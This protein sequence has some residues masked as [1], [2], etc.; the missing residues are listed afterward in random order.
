MMVG[1][2][3]QKHQRNMYLKDMQM[4]YTWCL[5]ELYTSR[6]SI[7]MFPFVYGIFANSVTAHNFESSWIFNIPKG[8]V[9]SGFEIRVFPLPKSWQLLPYI[10]T[11]IL[12]YSTSKYKCGRSLLAFINTWSADCTDLKR[13]KYMWYPKGLEVNHCVNCHFTA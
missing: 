11:H 12:I 13:Y 2:I 4:R 6:I 3:I 5:G 9:F 7:Y 1:N 8:C 10:Y